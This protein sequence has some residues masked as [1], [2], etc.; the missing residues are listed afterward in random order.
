MNK[1]LKSCIKLIARDGISVTYNSITKGSYD[2]ESGLITDTK[3]EYTVTSYPRHLKATEYDSPSLIGK[4]AYMFYIANN[5]LG[6]SPKTGD[7][8]AINSDTY[9][10]ISVQETYALGEVV[11]YRVITVKG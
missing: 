9:S 10:V 1:F 11:L 2:T 6:F 5:S 4:N 7:S 3:T 8:I